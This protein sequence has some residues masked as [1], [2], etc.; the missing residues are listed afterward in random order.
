VSIYEIRRIE[1]M[2]LLKLRRMLR[3]RGMTFD[4]LS[5]G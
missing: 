2:A 5:M 4:N 1:T 3:A